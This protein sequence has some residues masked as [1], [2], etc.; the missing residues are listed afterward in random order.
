VAGLELV[1][2]GVVGPDDRVG[3]VP[4]TPVGVADQ[5]LRQGGMGAVPPARGLG[6]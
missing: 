2:D 5:H 3:Q 6:L 1:G 4:G